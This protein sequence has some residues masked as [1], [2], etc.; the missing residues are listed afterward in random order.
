MFEVVVLYAFLVGY[1]G[2]VTV[3]RFG[4]SAIED[5]QMKADALNGQSAPTGYSAAKYSCREVEEAEI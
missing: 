1:D 4:E 5:C 3:Q 2:S